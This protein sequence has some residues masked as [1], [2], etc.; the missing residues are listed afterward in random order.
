AHE[1]ARLALEVEVAGVLRLLVHRD[2]V[3]VVGG[4]RIGKIQLLPARML[5]QALHDLRGA[6]RASL[7][8]HRIEGFQPLAGLL[9]I[10]VLRVTGQVDTDGTRRLLRTHTVLLSSEAN[11]GPRRLGAAAA[12]AS[13]APM[14]PAPT[15]IRVAQPTR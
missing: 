7:S 13:G 1:V 2:G 11:D 6:I 15:A 8:H 5:D 9:R 14:S 4:Q 3:D 12:G 10:R